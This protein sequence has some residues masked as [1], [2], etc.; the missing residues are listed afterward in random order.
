MLAY[1]ALND[2]LGLEYREPRD[3]THADVFLCN[4][5]TKIGKDSK[6]PKWNEAFMCVLAT[7]ANEPVCTA[8][9]IRIWRYYC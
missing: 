8:G 9:H 5:Q 7:A 1:S 3:I 6:N 2:D 4:L